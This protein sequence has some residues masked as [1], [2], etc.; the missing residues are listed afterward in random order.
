MLSVFV[1]LVT[2]FVILHLF[3]IYQDPYIQNK[4]IDL[5]FFLII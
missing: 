4:I 5:N 2:F 1:P 3:N